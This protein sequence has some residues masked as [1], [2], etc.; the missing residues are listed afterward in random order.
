MM[1]ERPF[2]ANWQMAALLLAA[3]G[4][5]SLPRAPRASSVPDDRW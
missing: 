3:A 4:L 1:S 5:Y 2:L